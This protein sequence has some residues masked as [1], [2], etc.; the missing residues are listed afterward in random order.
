MHQLKDSPQPLGG[1]VGS[2]PSTFID[3]R[4]SFSSSDSHTLQKALRAQGIQSTPASNLKFSELSRN[5]QHDGSPSIASTRKIHTSRSYSY[6]LRNQSNDNATHLTRNAYSSAGS[7]S[8]SNSNSS[9]NTNLNMPD[10][11]PSSSQFFEVM[12][13]GKIKVSHKRVPFSFIDDAL[14]KFKAYDTQ[15]IRAQQETGSNGSD[16]Q[17]DPSNGLQ[18]GD[19]TNDSVNN[20][21]SQQRPSVTSLVIVEE[22]EQENQE[23]AEQDDDDTSSKGSFNE[24]VINTNYSESERIDIQKDAM[25]RRKSLAPIKAE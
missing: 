7:I 14:P 15:R 22:G 24:N 6:D 4:T 23:K 10:I 9:S 5:A 18:N 19:S 2:I 12:Y 16:N 11:S 21:Q 8:T 25:L 13:V 1:S 17:T 3:G 20:G